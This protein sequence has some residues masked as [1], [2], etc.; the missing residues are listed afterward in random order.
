MNRILPL[1]LLLFPLTSCESL[2]GVAPEG[3]PRIE[4]EL[5]VSIEADFQS[6]LTDAD[7]ALNGEIH[8]VVREEANLGLRF[9]PTPSH[10]Y[11]ADHQRP[12]YLM[13]V[14]LDSL[15][16]NFN[17]EVVEE[18][19]EEQR[20]ITTVESV[21]CNATS[22]LLRRRP[23]G[24]ALRVSSGTGSSTVSVDAPDDAEGSYAPKHD[25][26]SPRIDKHDILKAV[27][28]AVDKTL[29][30]MRTAIDREFEPAEDAE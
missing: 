10:E 1:A 11:A 14:E 7:S 16:V 4:T 13:T 28:R 27:E 8:R 6:A 22:S 30:S 2:T 29:K 9:Y 19:G 12:A 26:P 23:N 3:T 15:V 20:M 5:V 24:P 25:G 18:E 21:T 17:H